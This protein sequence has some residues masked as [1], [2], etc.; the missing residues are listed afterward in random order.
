MVSGL[1]MSH[2]R[3]IDTNG[4]K[5]VRKLFVI[6][7][8]QLTDGLLLKKLKHFEVTLNTFEF[9]FFFLLLSLLMQTMKFLA[10][11]YCF[12]QYNLSIF[13]N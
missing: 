2:H 1:N 13:I 7:V 3:T 4:K 6:C 5:H 12:N 8:T 11:C 10:K 9:N